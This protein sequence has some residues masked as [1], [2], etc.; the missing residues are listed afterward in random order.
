MCDIDTKADVLFG[1]CVALG[2]CLFVAV[3]A[4]IGKGV[5]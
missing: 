3:L 5:S 2:A 4:L 1:L